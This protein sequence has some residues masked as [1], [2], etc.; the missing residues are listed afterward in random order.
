MATFHD[1]KGRTLASGD[2]DFASLNGKP[3]LVV[4]TASECGYTPQ[5]AGL[6]ALQQEHSARGFHVLGF[7]SNEFGG[8]E[9]G[10]AEA[11]RTFCTESYAVTFPLFAK[12][13]TAAGPG[14][15]PVFARLG[16]ATGEL[17]QWNFAKYLVG[18]DGRAIAFYPS[19]V[20]PDDPKLRA[21]IEKALAAA[22]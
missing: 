16:A 13:S 11:I 14:Q 4:N 22:Q 2:L 7:P 17:P 1:F 19:K 9:P 6:E 5:Y 12:T 18:R 8:Q 21:D 15:S 20:A 10:D 3:V